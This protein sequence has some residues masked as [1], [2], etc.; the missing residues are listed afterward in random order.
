M[1]KRM[2]LDMQLV[3]GKTYRT[4]PRTGLLIKQI[5]T[6][7]TTLKPL[8]IDDKPLGKIRDFLA[9]LHRT[10]TNM[11]PLFDLCHLP[12]VVP[13]EIEFKWDGSSGTFC[14]IKGELLKLAPP[15]AFPSNLLA[16][17]DEQT[18]HYW[19][20]DT[21]RFEFETDE[22]WVPNRE[23]TIYDLTPKTIEKCIVK[24]LIEIGFSNFTPGEADVGIRPYLDNAPLDILYEVTE[25]GGWDLLNMRAPPAGGTEITPFTL[26]EF[27]IEILGDHTFQ[28]RARNISGA[29]ITPPT[30]TKILLVTWIMLEYQRVTG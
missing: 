27:P 30:G 22:A 21:C 15:E 8:V 7:D 5:G 20:G 6:N 9:P 18:K 28:L 2:L 24:S 4:P 16:R 11:L 12:Y 25:V 10:T 26:K 14:R 29:N 23:V 17:F 19:T 3:Q 1:V 13:P